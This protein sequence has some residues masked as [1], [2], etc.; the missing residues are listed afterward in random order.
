MTEILGID[1]GGTGIKGAIV[2]TDKGA[3]QGERIRLATPR[4]AT[5]ESVTAV[6]VEITEHF[7]WKGPVGCGFPGVVRQ[8]TVLTAANVSKRWLERPAEEEFSKATG[9]PFHLANDADVAGIAEMRFGLSRSLFLRQPV[10]KRL[11]S[12]VRVVIIELPQDSLHMLRSDTA[13]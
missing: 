10:R 3:F 1:I 2:D 6:M 7:R 4:P 8:G 5:P 12:Q 9:C 13:A 11:L